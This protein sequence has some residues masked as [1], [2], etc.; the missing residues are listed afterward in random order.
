[1]RWFCIRDK[2]K[3]HK[4]IQTSQRHWLIFTTTVSSSVPFWYYLILIL[5]IEVQMPLDFGVHFI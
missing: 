1:M 5:L 4:G 3:D 2:Q